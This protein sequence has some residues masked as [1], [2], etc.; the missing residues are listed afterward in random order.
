[1]LAPINPFRLL[2]ASKFQFK[3]GPHDLSDLDPIYVRTEVQKLE[4]YTTVYMR[5]KHLL[6]MLRMLIRSNLSTKQCIQ[7]HRLTRSVFD[8][9]IQ[10]MRTHILRA[11]VHAGEMV[12][13]VAAQS[14]GEP[15]TQLTLNTFHFS[16]VGEKAVLTNTGVPRINEIINMSKDIK[17]P[18]MTIYLKEEF[19]QD[20]DL[21][22][23]V[24]NELEFTQIKD[25]LLQSEILYLPDIGEGKYQEESEVYQTYVELAKMLELEC[26]DPEHLSNWVLW[27]EFDRDAMVRKGIYM[28]DIH[29]VIATQCNV[30]MD[31]Q[32]VLSDMNSG[33][34]TLRIRV[35]QDFDEGEDY[36]SY[37]RELGDCILK[38][39]LRGIEG[40][41]KV[42]MTQENRVVYDP[43]GSAREIKEWVLNTDG[44]NLI[45]VLS[46]D[47]VDSDRTSTN[48]ITEIHDVFGLEAARTSIIHEI[49]LTIGEGGGNSLDYRHFSVLAD[50]MTYRG[51]I[52]QISRHGT[53]KSPFMGPL[54]RASFEV[55]DKVLVTAGVFA[56]KDNMRGTSANIIAGQSVL[57]GTNSF[58]LMMNTALL[59]KSQMDLPDSAA[60]SPAVVPTKAPDVPDS[61]LPSLDDESAFDFEDELGERKAE[62]QSLDA[63][64][65]EISEQP[66]QVEESDFSFGFD[67]LGSDEHRLPPQQVQSFSLN[68]LKSKPSTQRRR[69]NR[70]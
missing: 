33:H 52:M 30:D 39:T 19:A 55:M 31:V 27:M 26:P 42:G 69:R 21:A 24:K 67:L 20:R 62:P 65:D 58:D 35:R 15:L 16:G 4:A 13:I 32:C 10:R 44:S 59:P 23:T 46:N 9:I 60:P 43:D 17:T 66:Q 40:I 18:S 14:I 68:I 11:Y 25:I 56:D 6:E 61:E 12:G 50:L 41:K 51:V 36:V 34:L 1:M 8:Y 47:Y 64:L 5:E 38:L 37:F 2:K 57:S 22:L 3:I 70:K 49:S 7:K 63:Y 45:E 53:G 48:N 54:G 28:Q 29:E